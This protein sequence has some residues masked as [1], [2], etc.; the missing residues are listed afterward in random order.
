MS[1]SLFKE[2]IQINTKKDIIDLIDGICLKQR[3]HEIIKLYYIESYL[4]KEIA[5]RLG[6]NESTISRAKNEAIR[7]IDKFLAE[8][9]KNKASIDRGNMV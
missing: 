1:A 6:T 8:N 5:Q 7:K 9:A 3:E 2:Y 4:L